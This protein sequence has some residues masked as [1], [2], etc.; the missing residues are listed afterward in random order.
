MR[1]LLPDNVS[2]C[3]HLEAMHGQIPFHSLSGQ[4]RPRFREV[5]TPISWRS[6][7]LTYM[8][9]K[10]QDTDTREQL[11]YTGLLL[12]E[13]ASHGGT[14][15]IDY[16]HVFRKQAALNSSL[17]WNSLQPGLHA[18]AILGQRS[19]GGVFCTLCKGMD[20]SMPQCALGYMHQPVVPSLR[21][22]H[23]HPFPGTGPSCPQDEQNQCKRY[24]YRGML[25]RSSLLFKIDLKDAYRIV[26]IHPIDQS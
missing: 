5:S 11:C 10:T 6:C 25:G 13:A 14:G 18:S 24:A 12:R 9:V 19:S 26:P 16:D 4:A 3:Q 1:E 7:F 15:W 2:L 8:A 17:A 20:H 21:P 22:N 23:L